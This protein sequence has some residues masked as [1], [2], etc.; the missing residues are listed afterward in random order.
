MRNAD[1]GLENGERAFFRSVRAPR[2]PLRNL[3]RRTWQKGLWKL[4]FHRA[5]PDRPSTLMVEPTNACNLHCPA[6]PTGAGILNRPPRAMSFDEFRKILDQAL[7]PPGYLRRVT[8]FNYGEPFLCKDLLRMVRCA[9][10]RGLETFTS[11]N[12]QFFSGAKIADEV[13]ASGLSELLVCLDGADQETI[14]RY[15]KEANFDEILSGIRR[16]LAARAKAG[17]AAPIVE[18]QF[19]VMKHNEGQVERMRRIAADLGAD[20]FIVKTVG[21]SPGMPGFERL[22]EELLPADLSDSRYERRADG[23]FALKGK[24]G[25]GCEYVFSTLVVNSNGDVVPCC[26]DIH[27]EHVMG[28]LFRQPLAEIWLGEKFRDFRRR[29]SARRDAVAICRH[30]PEGRA[31]IRKTERV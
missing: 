8:L 15:R 30:C 5:L 26:Y 2:P 29:V 21:I 20:R 1:C 27:S 25:C 31:P 4:G 22:A 11:T 10:D 9:A 13:V 24:P 14:S 19:I 18:L 23:S 17:R 16:I 6:C 7:D 12:G 28:N 3:F